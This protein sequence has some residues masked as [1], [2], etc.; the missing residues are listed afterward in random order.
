MSLALL[1]VLVFIGLGGDNVDI[2]DKVFKPKNFYAK[3]N[4]L[5]DWIKENL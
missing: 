1:L 2:S 5:E 3:Y 4:T